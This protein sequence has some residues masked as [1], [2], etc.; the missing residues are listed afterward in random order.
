[1]YVAGDYCVQKEKSC[2]K[3]SLPFTYAGEL[4]DYTVLNIVTMW[5]VQMSKE[6]YTIS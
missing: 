4:P 6:S 1:M 3:H 2:Q 5:E